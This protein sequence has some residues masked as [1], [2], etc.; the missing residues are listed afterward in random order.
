M[1]WQNTPSEGSASEGGPQA[2]R[3]ALPYAL[4]PRL[5]LRPISV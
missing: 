4:S 1:A 3:N 5:A 2:D